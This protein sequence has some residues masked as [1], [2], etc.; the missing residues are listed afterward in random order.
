LKLLAKLGPATAFIADDVRPIVLPP[1]ARTLAPPII[2]FDDV[3]AGYAPGQPVLRDLTLRI[4]TDDR[5]AL[6]GA[7]GNGKSTLAKLLA[8]R[9][10]PFSGNITRAEKL[11]IAYF[12][13]HQ[14]DELT[15]DA[16]PYDHV[17][18]LM[19]DATETKVRGRTG[20]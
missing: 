18:K 1:P 12:A 16:S 19:P 2:A 5:I 3:A 9:L 17:R 10:P 4:D 7:N 8:N 20:A 14:L 13:Q 11:S 6:L 15:E